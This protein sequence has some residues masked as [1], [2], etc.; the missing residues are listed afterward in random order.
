MRVACLVEPHAWKLLLK[1]F[2]EQSQHSNLGL[3]VN[4]KLSGPSQWVVSGRWSAVSQLSAMHLPQYKSCRKR[5]DFYQQTPSTE[6]L[7]VKIFLTICCLSQVHFNIQSRK[8]ISGPRC[9]PFFNIFSSIYSLFSEE[10]SSLNWWMILKGF[11]TVPSAGKTSGL[12]NI[13]C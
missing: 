10:T 9:S 7:H 4:T 1:V 2:F 3:I 13:L 11:Q 6:K 12:L 5:L 8:I